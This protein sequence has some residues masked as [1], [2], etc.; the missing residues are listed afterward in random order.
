MA[1]RNW[2]HIPNSRYSG[3]LTIG[4]SDSMTTLSSDCR[5]FCC[6]PPEEERESRWYP[7]GIIDCVKQ[8]KNVVEPGH[9]DR[10]PHRPSAI[11]HNPQ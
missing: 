3:R 1:A 2:G 11:S 10:A 9:V 7:Q 6:L 4:Y 8:R 5:L